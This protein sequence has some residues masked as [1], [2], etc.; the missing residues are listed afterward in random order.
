M[1]AGGVLTKVPSMNG[2]YISMGIQLMPGFEHTY[3]MI[4]DTRGI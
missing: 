4:R 3:A 2:N 1:F